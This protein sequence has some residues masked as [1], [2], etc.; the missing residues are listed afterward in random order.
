M[1]DSETFSQI[2]SDEN[3]IQFTLLDMEN[4]Q[5]LGLSGV[6]RTASLSGFHMGLSGE[7]RCLRTRPRPQ[8]FS[9]I[10]VWSC[11][12]AVQSEPG[13]EILGPHNNRRVWSLSGPVTLGHFLFG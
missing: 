7:N 5:T 11:G 9:N 4:C 3:D 10:I 13:P 8:H 1:S 12:P 2:L 6:N